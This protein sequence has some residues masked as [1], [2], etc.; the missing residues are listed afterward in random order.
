MISRTA[1]HRETQTQNRGGSTRAA[2]RPRSV[3]QPLATPT[4]LRPADVQAVAEVINPLIADA[5]ALYVKTKNFHWHLAG[6]HFRDYHRMFDEQAEEVLGS[7]DELAE[8]VRRLGGTT[9]RSIAHISQAQTIDDDDDEFVPAHEMVRRLLE[10]NQLIAKAQR[11]AIEVCEEH[12]D[13]VTGNV[14]QELLDH[15]EKRTWFLFETLQDVKD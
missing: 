3:P 2:D 15:T 11:H 14:L 8:R 6:P 5:F 10:D 13:S 7:I 12:H 9:I 1:N 4:D